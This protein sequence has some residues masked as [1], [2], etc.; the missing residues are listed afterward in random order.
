[1]PALRLADANANSPSGTY[2]YEFAWPS[3]AYGGSLG[4]FHGL[5]IPFVFDTLSNDAPL[6]RPFLGEA[7]PQELADTMHGVW[8]SFATG[9]D[10]GWPHY[11]LSRRAT[12]RFGTT[13]Q[14]VDDPRSWGRALWEGIR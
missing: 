12:M 1:M 8:V 13:A 14:V 6:F 4:A 3:P 11:D 2:M 7:P 5:E 10:P 9:G